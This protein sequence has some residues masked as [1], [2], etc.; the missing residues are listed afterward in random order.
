LE[1]EEALRS[2]TPDHIRQ[3]LWGMAIAYNLVRREMD[4][5]ARERKLPPHRISFRTSLMLVRDLFVWAATASPG[6]LP[7]MIKRMRV[8]MNQLILPPRRDRRYPRE[9]KIAWTHYPR[10]TRHSHSPSNHVLN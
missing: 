4:L 1:Q 2:E 7:K 10:N 9:V 8:D 5:L 6:S 3:E